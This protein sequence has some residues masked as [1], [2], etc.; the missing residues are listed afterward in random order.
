MKYYSV[1]ATEALELKGV[2]TAACRTCMSCHR[3]LSA[4][5][6]GGSNWACED[7]WLAFSSGALY[8]LLRALDRSGQ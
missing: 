6:G 1:R 5:G 7:C 3:I 4:M 8:R 2:R